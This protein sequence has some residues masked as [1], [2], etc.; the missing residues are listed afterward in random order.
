MNRQSDSKRRA[1][2]RRANRDREA[3]RQKAWRKANPQKKYA[4]SPD[5]IRV[6][7]M[8]NRDKERLTKKAYK[9]SRRALEAGTGGSFTRQELETLIEAQN[10]HCAYCDRTGYALQVEHIIPIA[11]GGT[12]YIWNL[13]LACRKCNLDKGNKTPEQWINRWYKR[14]DTMPDHTPHTDSD[15][16][17]PTPD[18]ARALAARMGNMLP[19]LLASDERDA[20]LNQ[21]AGRRRQGEALTAQ[22]VITDLKR[23]L[24]QMTERIMVYGNGGRRMLETPAHV[25]AYVE[26][27]ATYAMKDYPRE[28]EGDRHILNLWDAL[29]NIHTSARAWRL[30]EYSGDGTAVIASIVRAAHAALNGRAAPFDDT[31]DDEDVTD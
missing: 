9:H 3:A 26:R 19:G 11:Q 29:D 6:W 23:I 5:Y 1:A 4:A 28:F 7:R 30:G 22:E 21:A 20:R 16:I 25:L 14:I 12:S 10:G 17:E 15:D 13:C 27:A 8:E 2:Y 24:G 31:E 18:Q